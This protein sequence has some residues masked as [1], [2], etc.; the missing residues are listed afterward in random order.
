VTGPRPL[1]PRGKSPSTDWI[2][3]WVDPRAGLG[4]VEKIL[5]LTGTQTPTPGREARS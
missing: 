3:G 5:N 2:G 1:Y 4:D